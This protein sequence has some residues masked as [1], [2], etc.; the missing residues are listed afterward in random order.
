MKKA[1]TLALL[2]VNALKFQGPNPKSQ[3]IEIDL[4]ETE[5]QRENSLDQANFTL[6]SDL[7]KSLIQVVPP[8]Q[9]ISLIQKDTESISMINK[10]NMGY[11]G[12]F[13][14]GSP[15]QQMQ[16]IFDSGSCWVW[17]LSDLCN[18]KTCPPKNSKFHQKKSKSYVKESKQL[19]TL[20]YGKGAV[21]GQAS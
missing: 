21:R 8:N 10:K 15:P 9:G 7:M 18:N 6:N 4:S 11:E 3:L 20:T 14:F 2:G 16:V 12:Q 13:W 17:L 19:Q 1:L 5:Y